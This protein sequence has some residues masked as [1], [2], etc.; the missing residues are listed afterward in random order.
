MFSA[1]LSALS[2]FMGGAQG[3]ANSAQL[4][5][6]DYYQSFSDDL[7]SQIGSGLAQFDFLNGNNQ[8]DACRY[9]LTQQFYAIGNRSRE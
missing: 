8:T 7:A 9:N 3:D 5:F 6:N 1:P 4:Q 2:G